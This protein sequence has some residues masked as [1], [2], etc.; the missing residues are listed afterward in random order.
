MQPVL[1]LEIVCRDKHF[2]TYRASWVEA[3]GVETAGCS[4]WAACWIVAVAALA[5]AEGV[6]PGHDG[7]V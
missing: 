6:E 2:E 5:L 3:R 7:T 4:T 1:M